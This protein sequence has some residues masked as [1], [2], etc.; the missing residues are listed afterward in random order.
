[1]ATSCSHVLIWVRDIH[2]AVRD[3]RAL[4]FKVEY[5][6]PEK[7]ALHAHIWFTEGPIIELLSFPFGAKWFKWPIEFLA[8]RGSG[9]RMVGWAEK[10]EGFC[11][12][13]VVIDGADFKREL[14]AFRRAGVPVGR[15]IP[16]RRTNIHGQRLRYQYAYPKNRRLPILLTPYDPPQ[17]PKHN[18]HPNGSTRMS[19]V[20]MG[21]RDEDREALHRIIGDDPTFALDTAET[22]AVRSVELT[23]LTHEL[24]AAL[25]HG[26]VVQPAGS[27]SEP[28]QCSTVN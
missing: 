2:R 13:A 12:V 25:L 24:D 28:V 26:A 20:R 21:V 18:E 27:V 16:W 1:M 6:V 8:G 23:G 19:R 7:K 3:Y 22:T 17:H 15:A 4:G 11:D 14:A 9:R 5:A 10:G